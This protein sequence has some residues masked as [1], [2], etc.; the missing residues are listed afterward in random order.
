[1]NFENLKKT[2]KTA[3][4]LIMA[5]INRQETS[6]DIIPSECLASLSVIEAL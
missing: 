4:N 2:D 1:M 6:L 5:E 3:Y